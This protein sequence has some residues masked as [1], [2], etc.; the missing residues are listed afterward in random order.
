[1]RKLT[2]ILAFCFGFLSTPTVAGPGHD[3][4]HG[5]SHGPVSADA[6]SN[7]AMKKVD[8]LAKAGKI[9]GSWSGIQPT[10][11]EQKTYANG[12]EWVV[13]FKNDKVSDVSKQ[14]LYLFYSLDGHYI[15]ANYTGQ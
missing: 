10:A 2:I 12:P 4:E 13:T 3:H 5:H 15:A 7:K 8:Q 1:M 9:N 6:A 11:V 14:T